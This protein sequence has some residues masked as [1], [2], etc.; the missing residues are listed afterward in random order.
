[1]PDGESET[2]R[3]L[4]TEVRK[5]TEKLN[6]VGFQ[7]QGEEEKKC[8]KCVLARCEG[9]TRCPANTRRCNKCGEIGH[10]SRSPLCK[11]KGKGKGV[12]KVQEEESSEEEVGKVEEETV[13]GS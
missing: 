8:N 4:Q 2:T 10:F 9:G 3:A 1:M 6:K 5:L 11:G 13:A 12:R 7:H